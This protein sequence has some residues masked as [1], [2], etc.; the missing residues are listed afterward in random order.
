MSEQ[1]IDMK[2][3]YIYEN[4]ED[5]RILCTDKPDPTYKVISMSKDGNL[6][7]HNKH[8]K[9]YDSG[10]ISEYDLILVEGKKDSILINNMTMPRSCRE[11]R[12]LIEDGSWY[13]LRC[14]ALEY[15]FGESANDY[16]DERRAVRC[17]LKEVNDE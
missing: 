11:C 17:P 6:V 15:T 3:K 2:N 4:G 14:A 13:K 9:V 12:F 1:T 16:V 8:G 5:A 7:Y 10:I